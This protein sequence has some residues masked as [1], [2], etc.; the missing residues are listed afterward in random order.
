[1][2]SAEGWYVDPFG[3]H[4]ARWFSDGTP[5]ALVRDA[6]VEGRDPQPDTAVPN[7]LQPLPD[8]SPGNGD[9]RRADDA[10]AGPSGTRSGLNTVFDAF[11]QDIWPFS[12]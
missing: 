3:R 6:Q 12:S 11:E 1:V 4:E 10:E 9:L 7:M 2:E 5:T 8:G